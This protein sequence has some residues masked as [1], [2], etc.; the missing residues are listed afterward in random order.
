MPRDQ[1][2]W[3]LFFIEEGQNSKDALRSEATHQPI[4]PTVHQLAGVANILARGYLTPLYDPHHR[5]TFL[6]DDVGVGKTL[7]AFMAI[8]ILE[9][10]RRQFPQGCPSTPAIMRPWKKR[11]SIGKRVEGVEGLQDLT[12]E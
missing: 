12:D 9:Y 1:S 5:H 2:S 3:D 10:Y 7:Q 6:Q 4:F 8:A 11:W